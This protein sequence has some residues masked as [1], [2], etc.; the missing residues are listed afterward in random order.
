[1]I[2]S[3]IIVTIGHASWKVTGEVGTGSL[4]EDESVTPPASWLTQ[5][6]LL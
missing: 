2:H 5:C 6:P 4:I 3:R 1:M